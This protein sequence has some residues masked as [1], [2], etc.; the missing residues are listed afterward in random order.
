MVVRFKDT[1]HPVFK[2]I[3]ALSRGILKQKN[4]RE[5]IH[6]NA[7]A[8]NN[9]LLYR[10]I[11]SATQLS[12]YGAVACWCEEFDLKPDETSERLT[13]TEN[14]QILKDVRPQEVN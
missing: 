13:K 5:T 6:F 11:H 4:R 3:S 7:D 9:E 12:I 2:S 8:S 10:A 1:G 14:E